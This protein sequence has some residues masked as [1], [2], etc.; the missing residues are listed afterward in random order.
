M[1]NSLSK[2]TN[3][4]VKKK[5]GFQKTAPII[6]TKSKTSILRAELNERT[7]VS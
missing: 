2:F 4:T 6:D 7:T 5:T 3:N 1:R